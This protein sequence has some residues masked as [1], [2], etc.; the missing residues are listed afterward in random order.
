[1]KEG[2]SSADLHV[3]S[4]ELQVLIG[5]HFDKAYQV[6]GSVTLRFN[7]LGGGR[8]ELFI[9]PG[10]WL[11]FRE[12][13]ERPERS[14]RL[15]AAL[16][17][18]LDNARVVAVAQRGFDRVLT[19]SLERDAVYVLVIELFGK[20]N[21][22]LVRDGTI[23]A[24]LRT[25]EFR[26]RRV[27]VGERYDFPPAI[28]DPVTLSEEEFTAILRASK[29]SLVKTLAAKL[30]LGGPLAEEIC[31]RSGIEKGT[32]TSGLDAAACAAVHRAW[33]AILEDLGRPVPGVIRREGVPVDVSSLVLHEHG[34]LERI[35]YPTLLE[36]VAAY[37]DARAAAP[38]IDPHVEKLQRR[39][40][41]Q[42]D[43][44]STAR[45]E[46]VRL[47]LLAELLYAHY[48]DFD[49][50]LK[51]VREGGEP[52]GPSV[53]AVDRKAHAVVVSIADVEEVSLD[54]RQTL[55]ENVRRIYDER[56]EA[57]SK[58]AG[59]QDALTATTK[60]IEEALKAAAR[61]AKKAR[62]KVKPT[63][64]FWF[65]AYRWFF[66]SEGFLVIGGRDAK[67]NDAVVKKHLKEG[68]RYA[69]AD[70][71][72][73]PS[74]VIK[75]GS[76]AGEATLSEACAFAL[77]MSK[78]WSAG[79]ASGG[80]FWVLPEQVSK[81]A[82]S[83]EFLPRGAFMVRGKRN[84]VNDIP[85]RLAVAEIEIDGHRKI[86][87]APESAI[88]GKSTRSAVIGPGE[89]DREGI[90][91]R[92]ARAFAVPVEEIQRILPPGGSAIL[93]TADLELRPAAAGD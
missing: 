41:Q 21:V 86:V 58:A 26:D 45:L 36:A 17:Q 81:E 51:T 64:A 19:I 13:S 77:G 24:T 83:G 16:R 80:A 38:R 56:K 89:E 2:L 75:E 3:L 10:H 78:A 69:H 54:Y 71:H 5:G 32:K 39:L 15:A 27:A 62:E 33:R 84:F 63:K 22:T 74:C 67:T 66:S 59:A 92:F 72:G 30:N 20:G 7:L 18:A 29:E 46:E 40:E 68:D 42:Q 11:C 47:G 4:R 91:R 61:V 93:S 49:H 55:D 53:K 79:I 31:A 12:L 87:C 50:L 88:A 1:M 82:E 52:E 73:A 48:A 14:T 44:L 57:R 28:A 43:A 37:L 85:L 9:E 76:K 25:Q 90:V 23:V 6:E 70:V 35:P 65:E 34:S 60:E 8:R